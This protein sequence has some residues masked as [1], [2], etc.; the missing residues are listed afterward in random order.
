MPADDVVLYSARNA[1][2][3]VLLLLFAV[4]TY[5]FYTIRGVTRPVAL[6]WIVAV[7]VFYLSKYYYGHQSGETE[8]D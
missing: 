5:Q 8:K 4:S 6:L 7:G 3:V 1:F 2:G